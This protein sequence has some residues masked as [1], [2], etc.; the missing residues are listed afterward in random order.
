MTTES[1]TVLNVEIKHNSFRLYPYKL[2][3]WN[4]KERILEGTAPS[5]DRAFTNFDFHFKR[6][7]LKLNIYDKTNKMLILPIGVGLK[8]IEEKLRE[9]YTPYQIIDNSEYYPEPRTVTPN[10]NEKY[11]NRS[12]YQAFSIDFL[13]SD[14]LF[15]TKLLALAT[16]VGKTF[17]SVAAAFRLKMVMLVISPTLSDQWLASIESYTNCNREN[18]GIVLLRGCDSVD[19]AMSK[20]PK[21]AFYVTTPLTIGNWI[22][23][24]NNGDDLIKHLGIG[25]QCFDEFHMMYSENIFVNTHLNT[26]YTFYLTATPD[27]TDYSEK[28]IFKRIMNEI[29]VYGLKTFAEQNYYNIRCVNYN[30]H[31]EGYEISQCVTSKGLSAIN[32]W[33]YLFKTPWRAMYVFS[34]IKTMIDKMIQSPSYTKDEKYLI[35]LAKI[36]HIDFAKQ[37][38]NKVYANTD[39]TTGNYTS[40]VKKSERRNETM[41]NIIFCTLGGGGVGLDIPNLRAVFVAVPYSSSIITMQVRGRLRELSDKEV[42]L[43]DF[44]DIGFADM[45]YQ[46]NKRMGILKPYSRSYSERTFY[47]DDKNLSLKI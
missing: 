10:L 37:W 9:E 18:G 13:T 24:G 38:F 1:N 21:A 40:E 42:Y 17:C 8:F 15:H 36:E 22:E 27:R 12:K 45:K 32:Y 33:N 41:N 39:L 3:R 2:A 29:P 43:F 7:K 30:T 44:C 25:I 16:G 14:K 28:K 20:P 6:Y 11:T 47:W 35:Y 4:K 46:R 26:K 31:P 34:I 5:L 23:K 19:R